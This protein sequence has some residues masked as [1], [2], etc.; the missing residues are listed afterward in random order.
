MMDEWKHELACA[1]ERAETGWPVFT[2]P[3]IVKLP[4]W[5]RNGYGAWTIFN[6]VVITHLQASCPDDV[7]RY[8]I[9]HELGH[10]VGRHQYL[11][12]LWF[13][14]TGIFILGSL[15][16]SRAAMVGLGIMSIVFGTLVHPRLNLKR[17]IFADRIA[18]NLYG[19]SA[20]M[21]S[22][23]WM[24]KQVGDSHTAERQTRLETLRSYLPAAS[25]KRAAAVLPGC[26]G[27]TLLEEYGRRAR[28]TRLGSGRSA[29]LQDNTGDK[30]GR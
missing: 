25:E 14:G 9:G 1:V 17:E 8:I 13:A 7:R 5:M 24:S 4:A 6:V 10:L 12:Y 22:V 19:S 3:R 15:L 11:H 26:G 28:G 21:T 29:V 27:E 30:S 20:V 18:A 23:M 16:E 2:R